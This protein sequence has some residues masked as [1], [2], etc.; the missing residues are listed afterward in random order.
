MLDLGDTELM[1]DPVYTPDFFDITRNEDG[2]VEL[3]C[4][5]CG[6]RFDHIPP[7]WIEGHKG[8]KVGCPHCALSS[9]IPTLEEAEHPN[10]V[11]GSGTPLAKDGFPHERT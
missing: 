9:R 10:D 1:D 7:D 8:E 4:R 3:R 6:Y 2:V 11:P 5:V